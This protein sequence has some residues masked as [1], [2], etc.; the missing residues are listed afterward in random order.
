MV[1][2]S[3]GGGG[4]ETVREETL[5]LPRPPGKTQLEQA[6]RTRNLNPQQGNYQEK[7][8]EADPGSQGRS[9]ME[10]QPAPTLVL[11]CDEQ[12]LADR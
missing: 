12:M 3:R 7:G 8:R 6:Q 10:P 5:S 4:M 1:E 2:A 9:L 11:L